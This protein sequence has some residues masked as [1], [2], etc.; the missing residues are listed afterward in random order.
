MLKCSRSLLRR[1]A[2]LSSDL[3]SDDMKQCVYVTH[4]MYLYDLIQIQNNK[5]TLSLSSNLCLDDMKRDGYVTHGNELL[6][7]F[8]SFNTT[9]SHLSLDLTF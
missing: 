3:C 4:R 1:S 6:I 2:T 9:K 8:E 5:V 7:L